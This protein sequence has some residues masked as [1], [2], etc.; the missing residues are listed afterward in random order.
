LSATGPGTAA[1]GYDSWLEPSFGA[2]LAELDAACAGAGPEAFARFRHLDA[3]LWALLLTKEYTGYPN[4]HALLPDVPEPSLQEL[5]TGTSGVSLAGQ[6]L[7]FYRKLVE[8]YAESSATPLERSS[9]LDF[10]CG[11]GRLTRFLA[12]DVPPGQLYGCDPVVQI[13]DVC[14][15]TRVPAVLARSEFLPSRLP[16][17]QTFDLAFSFSVFT[18]LSEQAH[19]AC[20]EA[21]HGGLR[22][23][24]ILVLTIRPVDY[25]ALSEL[26]RPVLHGLG[27]ASDVLERPSYLFVA[28]PTAP[29]Q[30]PEDSRDATYG[31][32]VV[33]MAYVRER[34]SELFE[35]LRVD[36]LLGDLHQIMLTLRRR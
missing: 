1:H 11:W 36:L 5:W 18:H 29:L 31:E 7:A 20:L 27:G 16:F 2:E 6:S 35:L 21:L 26:M 13:L 8:R 23:G 25:L 19:F 14:R 4:I 9:V 15:T 34:W 3:D 24:G 33:T 30:S 10:G 28:H 32:A 22:P 12:R 17:E